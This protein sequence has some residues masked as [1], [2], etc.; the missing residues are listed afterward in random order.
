MIFYLLINPLRLFDGILQ[1]HEAHNSYCRFDQRQRGY[2][3]DN[4]L[5]NRPIFHTP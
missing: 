1:T 2:P 3:E 5:R 4:S